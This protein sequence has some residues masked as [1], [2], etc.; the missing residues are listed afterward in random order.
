[1]PLKDECR[2][3]GRVLSYSYLKRCQKCGRLFCRD[4]MVP[5]IS[6][7]DPNR[8]LCLNCAR[9]IVS[10][11]TY[12]KYEGLTN[13]L[14]FRAAFTDTVKLSLAEIDGIIRNNLPMSA[15]KNEKW[16][17]NNPTD[18]HAK[19]WMDVGWKVQETNLKEGYVVFHKVEETPTKRFRKKD[20]DNET[21]KPF[22]PIPI[23]IPKRSKP[24]KTKV[25]K[26]YARLKNIE[27]QRT[28]MPT[29]P[30]SFKPKPRHE[31]KLFK[32]EKKPQ[33]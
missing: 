28:S 27:R 16:W 15:Y 9:K 14:K 22:T 30:G 25:S 32:P 2:I 8:M 13:H 4:C 7:G 19:A 12:T 26:L 1:M 6:T 21:K 33:P 3:C 24:S 5:D 31:K 17:N 10:P 20:R 23:R 11:K 18:A 29:Y